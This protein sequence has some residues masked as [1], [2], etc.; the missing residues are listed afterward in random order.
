MGKVGS[1]TSRRPCSIA[2]SFLT[3]E[4]IAAYRPKALAARDWMLAHLDE[5]CLNRG[6]FW[7]ITG[8]LEPRPKCNLA[9]LFGWTLQTLTQIHKI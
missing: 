6:G 4:E 1:W 8:K 7:K 2:A 3:E 5:E 9:W